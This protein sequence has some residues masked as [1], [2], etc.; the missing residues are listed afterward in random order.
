M[1]YVIKNPETGKYLKG[2]FDWTDDLQYARTFTGPNH[3]KNAYNQRYVLDKTE[4][5]VQ[6]VLL[7]T[8]T[9]MAEIGERL[10]WLASLEEAGVNNWEGI[11]FA[12]E[13][14][15]DTYGDDDAS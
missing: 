7:V 6:F 14:H 15:R 10:E 13:I 1:T 12:H 9:R 4:G 11:S 5:V 3:A 8:D 2:R